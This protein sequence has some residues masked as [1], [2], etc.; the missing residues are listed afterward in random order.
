MDNFREVIRKSRARPTQEGAGVR[1]NR[2]FGEAD[3]KLDPFLLLDHF[4]SERPEDYLAGFPW[5][6]HRG[7]ETVTYM[8]SGKVEHGDSLG[9]KGVIGPGDVQWMTAGSGIVHQEMPQRAPVLEGFQ[10]WSNLPKSH[11]MMQPRYQDISSIQLMEVEIG[12]GARAKIICGNFAG[13][14]GPVGDIVT[15]PLYMDVSLDGGARL[16]CPLDSDHNAF[17]YVFRGAAA[18]GSSK[19]FEELEL[20]VFG[21][22]SALDIRA[23]D[24]DARMLLVAGKPIQEPVAW[25]GPI[26]MNTEEE[27]QTAFREYRDGT[28]LKHK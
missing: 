16:E 1:L 24:G 25:G 3:E 17:V 6:P 26:V 18:F 10:L 19:P 8:I 12:V 20:A 2:V 9:N 14:S 7:I 28:F 21:K 23:G 13:F 5:H 4:G 15:D 27:L 22:G 11:K